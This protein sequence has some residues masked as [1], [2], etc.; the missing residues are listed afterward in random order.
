VLLAVLDGGIDELGVLLL[1]RRGEDQGGVGGGILGVVL[2]DGRKVTRVADDD[3]DRR[4]AAF[5][6]AF[7]CRVRGR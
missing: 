5:L 7:S 3:L 4:L 2:V 1:L 6:C